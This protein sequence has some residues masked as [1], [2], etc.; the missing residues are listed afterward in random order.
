MSQ[1]TKTQGF[2]L[3]ELMIVV[4]LISILAVIAV[5]SYQSYTQRARFA[6]IISTANAYKTAVAIAIQQGYALAELTNGVHGI[7][8]S[9]K[10]TKNLAALKVEKGVITAIATELAASATYILR[11]N[12]D[13]SIWTVNGT[14]Q[15]AGLCDG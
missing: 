14:C 1:R 12:S 9:P 15:K 4:A 3:I 6:E 11:P 13:A 10:P 2:S 5:P 7:P 8:A